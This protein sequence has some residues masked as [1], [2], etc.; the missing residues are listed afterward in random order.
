[1]AEIPTIEADP[2]GRAAA[3]RAQRDQMLIGGKA[4]EIDN[5]Q[6]NGVRRRVKFAQADAGRLDAAIAEA[7]KA[8][9]IKLGTYRRK[10]F[11]V[12]PRGGGW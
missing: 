6:G 4:T 2:C 1:M 12:T 9:Q 8:C 5:E 7:D 10:R 3:L 11:A